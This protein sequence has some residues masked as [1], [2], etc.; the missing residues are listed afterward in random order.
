MV[1]PLFIE[2]FHV[3]NVILDEIFNEVYFYTYS[4]HKNSSLR[5]K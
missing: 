5:F 3:G 1:V 4:M 2:Q